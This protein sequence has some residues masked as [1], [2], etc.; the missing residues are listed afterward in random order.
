[1]STQKQPVIIASSEFQQNVGETLRRVARDGEH[2][3]V[4]AR[5]IPVAVL[6]P[7]SDYKQLTENA[8]E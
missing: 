4:A 8:K 2:V 3:I 7:V 6:V 1:M 5:D